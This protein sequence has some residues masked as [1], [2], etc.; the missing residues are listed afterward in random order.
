VVVEGNFGIPEIDQ[1]LGGSLLRGKSYL[2]EAD[3][4]TQPQSLV[5]AFTK[6]ALKHKEVV[7]Y[8]SNE[9]PAEDVIAWLKDSGINVDKAVKAKQ[10]LFL[11]LWSETEEKQAGI[12]RVGNPGDPHKVMFVYN[13]AYDFIAKR[14]TP[15]PSRVI[16]KSCSGSITNFGFERAHKLA[17]RSV[18][19]MKLVGTV[20]LSVLVPKMHPTT[21]SESYKHLHDGVIQLTLVEVHDKLQKFLR[22]LKSP[23]PHYNTRRIPYDV[24]PT[25]ISF[26]STKGITSLLDEF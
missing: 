16:I 22:I 11:D 24:T 5:L 23:L 26:P 2:L 21:V 13:Q 19:M 6:Y 25:G 9:E 12:L 20:G 7:V 4:G 15:K 14:T 8:C 1:L 18:R 10:L 17:Q 3:N